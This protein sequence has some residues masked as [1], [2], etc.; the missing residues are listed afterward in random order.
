VLRYLR[1]VAATVRPKTLAG[2]AATLQVF[3]GWLAECHPEVTSLA[4]LGR[5]HLEAFLAFDRTRGWRGRVA[6]DQT[7][8]V[9]HHIRNVVDLRSFFDDLASWGWVDRPPGQVLHRS[10]IRGWVPR[11]PARWAPMSTPR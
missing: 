7:I 11:C 1:A 8:S 9:R 6:R 3:T 5:A 10:D 4:Q 2:R